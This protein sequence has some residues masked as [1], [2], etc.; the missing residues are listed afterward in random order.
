MLGEPEEIDPD[1]EDKEK[2][3]GTDHFYGE[4]EDFFTIVSAS[5]IFVFVEVAFHHAESRR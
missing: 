3:G 5:G 1:G 2:D 4:N